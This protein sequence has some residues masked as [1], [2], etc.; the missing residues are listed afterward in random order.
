MFLRSWK[1]NKFFARRVLPGFLVVATLL[2]LANLTRL[3]LASPHR[4]TDAELE[5]LV[6]VQ[7][8]PGSTMKEA[9]NFLT[10]NCIEY[11]SFNGLMTDSFELRP[12][13]IVDSDSVS[14]TVRGELAPQ[15]SNVGWLST[16]DILIYMFFNKNREMIGYII[17]TQEYEL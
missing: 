16:G 9:E 4:W 13:L 14:L 12:D 10:A 15:R 5:R 11:R 3:W 1:L 7:L 2:V 8:P 17:K 6:N